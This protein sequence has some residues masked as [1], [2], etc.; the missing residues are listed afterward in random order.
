MNSIL[1]AMIPLLQIFLLVVFVIIIYAIVGLEMFCGLMHH[2]CEAKLNRNPNT[3]DS[4]DSSLDR[5]K[6]NCVQT[7]NNHFFKYRLQLCLGVPLY[8]IDVPCVIPINNSTPVKGFVCPTTHP[9]FKNHT[10]ECRANWEG[11]FYGI[12]NFDNFP[13]S[14]LSVFQC[15]TTE[16]WTTML[17]KVKD[18]GLKIYMNTF[19]TKFGATVLVTAPFT[20]IP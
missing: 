6:S 14:M 12:I 5:C 4:L 1:R 20:Y 7:R 3:F 18:K 11:P 16:G 2:R 15:I 9:N 19:L 13:V 10:I 17:Y 8:P